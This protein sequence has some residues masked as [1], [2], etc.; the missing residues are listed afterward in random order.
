M[1]KD[2]DMGAE[3][4]NQQDQQPASSDQGQNEQPQ[5]TTQTGESSQQGGQ[6]QASE[7]EQQ[8]SKYEEFRNARQ[9]H[10]KEWWGEAH[11]VPPSGHQDRV[12]MFA[13]NPPPPTKEEI[14][15][16]VEA[17]QAAMTNNL[18][19]DADPMGVHLRSSTPPLERAEKQIQG[20]KTQGYD[21]TPELKKEIYDKFTLNSGLISALLEWMPGKDQVPVEHV[22]EL[23]K[24]IN[25]LQLTMS[26]EQTHQ[27]REQK[28][29]GDNFDD[30]QDEHKQLEQEFDD[31]Q[32][33]HE[34]LSKE[35][36]DTDKKLQDKEKELQQLKENIPSE[37]D[38]I[39]MEWLKEELTAAKSKVDNFA[40]EIRQLKFQRDNAGDRSGEQDEQN[41]VANEEL[42]A[43]NTKLRAEI[44]GLLGERTQLEAKIARTE[45][46]QGVLL[47][48]QP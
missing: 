26:E 12:L 34:D 15:E 32:K 14:R 6:A 30:F 16:Q 46:E 1:A 33:K 47:P 41:Q 20:L 35:K 38:E 48:G 8:A 37:T 36:D 43:E 44:N 2:H 3:R 21:V 19:Q 7:L 18:T 23:V 28:T 13:K 10:G 4:P 40:R 29:L 25:R 11:P 22:R 9:A 17:Y 42:K 39:E 31:L 5:Q 24:M 27:S 45:D